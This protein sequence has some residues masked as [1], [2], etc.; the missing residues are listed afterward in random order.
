MTDVRTLF[1]RA[2]AHAPPHVIRVPVA[3]ELLGGHTEAH[4]GLFYSTAVDRYAEMAFVPRHDGRI[5]LI[6]DGP[7][8]RLNRW[9]RE[10]IPGH[11]PAW[12]AATAAI[13]D[14]L[15]EAGRNIR[16]FNAAIVSDQLAGPESVSLATALALRDMFPFGV[17]ETGLTGTVKLGRDGA[18]PKLK[19]GECNWF[20][21][22]CRDGGLGETL[23]PYLS[24]LTVRAG[25]WLQVDRLHR[26]LERHPFP[27]GALWLICDSGIRDTKAEVRRGRFDM[28]ARAAAKRV[29]LKSLRSMERDELMRRR[30]ELSG[31]EFGVARFVAGECARVVAVERALREADVAQLGEYLNQSQHDASRAGLTSP[32]V[33]LLA[34]LAKEEGGCLG[35]RFTGCGFAGRTLNLVAWTHVDEFVESMEKKF[36]DRT[37]LVLKCH[38]LKMVDGVMA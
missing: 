16:G 28:L 3:L 17:S 36:E 24:S 35:A 27:G 22:I 13:I 33:D 19:P 2:F 11:V 38:R 23:L 1:K 6:R 5:E 34:E 21:E 29:G 32:E 14:H 9:A 8:R 10:Y 30:S 15:R 37:G 31:E 7:D 18:L 12:A 20:S 4:Q 26:S 25:D